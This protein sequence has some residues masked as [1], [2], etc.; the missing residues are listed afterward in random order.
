MFKFQ[1]CAK[2][3]AQHKAL[4]S[5]HGEIKGRNGMGSLTQLYRSAPRWFK[6]VQWHCALSALS[7]ERK[8]PHAARVSVPLF[9]KHPRRQ[10]NFGHQQSLQSD[11]EDTKKASGTLRFGSFFWCC[12]GL[13]S[14]RLRRGG[15][16]HPCL[17]MPPPRAPMWWA[18]ARC[19]LGFRGL[20]TRK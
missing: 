14:V 4:T 12:Y 7:A 3:S 6:A 15:A 5:Q 9:L 18:L 2:P 17:P 19:C 16:Q 1:N 13:T 11:P 8:Q 10:A 20:P